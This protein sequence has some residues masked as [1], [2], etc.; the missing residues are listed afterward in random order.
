LGL[1]VAVPFTGLWRQN[2]LQLTH[3]IVKQLHLVAESYIICSYRSRWP[4][5]KLLYTPS[6]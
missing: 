1:L 3:K 6:Y 5:R 2:S 4:V